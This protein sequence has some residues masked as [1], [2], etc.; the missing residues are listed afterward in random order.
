MYAYS[1][2][3]IKKVK[4]PKANNTQCTISQRLGEFDDGVYISQKDIDIN[5]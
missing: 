1:S 5:E 2:I 4:V 3:I